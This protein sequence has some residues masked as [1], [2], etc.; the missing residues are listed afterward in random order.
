[1]KRSIGG[2][3]CVLLI[4]A[5]TTI[6][7]K[8]AEFNSNH[9]KSF[10]K[11]STARE[12]LEKYIT[13][14][15]ESAHLQESGLGLEVFNKAVTGFMNLKASNKLPQTTS[16]LTVVDLAKSSHEKR[17][18]I[19][20]MIN[21]ELLINTWV[22]HGHGSGD[23]MAT[24]FSNKIDSHQSSLGFYITDDV[25]YGKNGRS[26]RLDGMD[27][28]FNSNA[29]E[30]AIVVHGA[31]YV[32]ENAIAQLSRLGR[33]YGCPAVS[34]EVSDKVIDLIKNKTVMYINGNDNPYN[35]KFLDPELAAS[36]V[37][38]DTKNGFMASL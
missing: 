9:N 16:I 30:R 1:M 26:L 12:L 38:P 22:S 17:M 35:S 37:F 32:G 18:W 8:T 7:W 11:P 19:I 33:S 3:I 31:D 5:I 10:K 14:I 25:Y 21:N 6:S 34:P 4:V 20:D 29:R 27:A 15:Y 28:G 23:D 36:Y 2:L 24:S 13:N